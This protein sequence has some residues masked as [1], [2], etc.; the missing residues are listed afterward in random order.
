MLEKIMDLLH[1]AYRQQVSVYKI[2]EIF[3]GIFSGKY[4]IKKLLSAFMAIFTLIGSL[5]FDT[6]V[7]GAGAFPGRLRPGFL[8]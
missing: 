4:P 5:I 6:P 3:K 7:H 2:I 1:F 8:R